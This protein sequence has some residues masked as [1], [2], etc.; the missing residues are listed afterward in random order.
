M[1]ILF[2][3]AGN[4]ARSQMADAWAHRYVKGRVEAASAWVDPK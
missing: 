2:V 1:K 4:S 3:C